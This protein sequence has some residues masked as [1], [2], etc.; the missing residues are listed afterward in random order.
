MYQDDFYNPVDPNEYDEVDS[1]DRMLEKEK[2]KDPG[3]N[4]I[5]RKALRKDGKTKNKKVIIY[6]TGGTGS[7]IR[8]A[9]TGEY[10]PNIVGSIEEDLFFKVR[11]ATGE[12]KSANGSSALFFVSPQHYANHMMCEVDPTLIYNW[13]RRRDETMAALKIEKRKN[14]VAIEVR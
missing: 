6:T 11:L 5:Y 12:C 9:E 10:F 7:R 2:R 3:Y 4:V 13:E 1:F 14:Y 8:D